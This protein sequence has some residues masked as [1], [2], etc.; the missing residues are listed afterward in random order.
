MGHLFIWGYLFEI[1]YYGCLII[2]LM[3]GLAHHSSVIPISYRNYCQMP[4]KLYVLSS[5][6]DERTHFDHS[7]WE[8]FFP[9]K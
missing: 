4:G 6:K 7:D 2:L 3:A 1:S 5:T 9:E 8:S